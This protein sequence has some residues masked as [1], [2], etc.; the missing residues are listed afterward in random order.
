MTELYNQQNSLDLGQI[1]YI[2][3]PECI[4]KSQEPGMKLKAIE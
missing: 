1:S 3:L 2:L 4:S